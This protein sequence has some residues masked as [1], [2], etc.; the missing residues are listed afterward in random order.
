M[1][2]NFSISKELLED[3]EDTMVH[4]D[5]EK[6]KWDVTPQYSFGDS[7]FYSMRDCLY[8]WDSDSPSKI[9]YFVYISIYKPGVMSFARWVA[10]V[11]N[12]KTAILRINRKRNDVNIDT[13]DS[14]DGISIK[15]GSHEIQNV[16]KLSELCRNFNRSIGKYLILSP[17]YHPEKGVDIY[18]L[19]Q[20][21]S[22][23]RSHYFD[24][25]TDGEDLGED[26]KMEDYV[27]IEKKFESNDQALLENPYLSSGILTTHNIIARVSPKNFKI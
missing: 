21:S 1:D 7:I 18:V 20:N 25:L 26:Y 10:Y 3:I 15:M 6:Y 17:Q 2:K 19:E 22:K 5:D 14:V 12:L 16:R 8:H 9:E 24:L 13:S 27:G 23:S 4:F 11:G